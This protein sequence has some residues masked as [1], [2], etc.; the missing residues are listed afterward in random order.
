M[1]WMDFLKVVKPDNKVAVWLSIGFLVLCI[2][3]TMGLL[4]AKF[5]TR[6]GEV[7]VRRA[8]GAGRGAIFRQFL[9]ETT[10]VGLAG[11]TL[12]LALSFAALALIR[13][14]SRDLSAVAYMAATLYDPAFA[15]L[16]Q[17]AG[18]RYRRAVTAVTLFGGFASTVFW[19]FAQVLLEAWGWRVAFGVFAALHLLVCLPIHLFAIPRTRHE[20]AKAAAEN[21]ARSAAFGDRRLGYLNA[22]FGLVSFMPSEIWSIG[23]LNSRPGSRKRWPSSVAERFFAL[24]P[25]MEPTRA[26]MLGSFTAAC[27]K[28]GRLKP[29]WLQTSTTITRDAI[30]SRIAFTI[31]T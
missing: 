19:P 21:G 18:V 20:S 29:Y 27:R 31:C 22:A 17:H 26:W 16:S 12:G 2:V 14:Q 8:L 23:F 3:N 25:S 10:V 11:G 1:Q 4:L 24:S 7:G 13:Q 6:A 9:V 28:A 5:S 15:T 30:T